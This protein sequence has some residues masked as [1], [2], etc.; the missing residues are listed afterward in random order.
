[1]TALVEDSPVEAEPA[2]F[3]RPQT[4]FEGYLANSEPYFAAVREAGD[5]VW[6]EDESKR[7]QTAQRLGLPADVPELELRRALFERRHSTTNQQEMPV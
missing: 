1:V 6:F 4:S 7:A 5:V 3:A 2:R